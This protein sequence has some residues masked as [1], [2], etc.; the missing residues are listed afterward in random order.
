MVNI[1]PKEL[2]E[3]LISKGIHNLYHANTVTTSCTFIEHGGLLSRGMVESYG[4]KQTSQSSD[5][6][7][8]KYDVWNKIFLDVFDLHDYFRRENRYGPVCFVLD[9]ELL[10]DEKLPYIQITRDNP[11]YWESKNDSKNYYSSIDEYIAIFDECKN[12]KTIQRKMITICGNNYIL[13]FSDYLR[14]IMLDN[15]CAPTAYIKIKSKLEQYDYNALLLKQREC[16]QCYCDKN[17]SKYDKKD[18]ERLFM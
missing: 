5:D 11:I 2:Y 18:I 7:D 8:K 6:I 1:D 14:Q 4:F 16:K 3:F 15:F 12:N 9:V 17:Y 13:P 10:L